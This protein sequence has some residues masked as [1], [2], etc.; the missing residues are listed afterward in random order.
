MSSRQVPIQ[1]CHCQKRNSEHGL[2]L[3]FLWT[4]HYVFY[5]IQGKCYS[6]TGIIL[7]SSQFPIA[8]HPSLHWQFILL[9]RLFLFLKVYLR[10]FAIVLWNTEFPFFFLNEFQAS[11]NSG[12]LRA[13]MNKPITKL[14]DNTQ[15]LMRTFP[16]LS[17]KTICYCTSILSTFYC[18][19]LFCVSC[20]NLCFPRPDLCWKSDPGSFCKL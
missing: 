20:R 11:L 6:F 13:I 1:V 15:G 18:Q 10:G 9:T 14:K 16:K 17:L 19:I 8:F 2:Q 5:M 12:E 3:L 4:E 7:L